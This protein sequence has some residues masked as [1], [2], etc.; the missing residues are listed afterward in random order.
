MS[1]GIVEKINEFYKK[2][3][4]EFILMGHSQGGA[5]TF[6][7][8]SYLY[9]DIHN[10]IPDDI[11]FK[12]YNSAAPKPGNLY[13]SYD[14]SYINRGGWA[15]RVVNTLDWVPETPI[16]VQT[17]EDFNEINP[18]TNFDTFT[19]TMGWVQRAI[20][21]SVFNKTDRSLR[22]AQKRLLKYLGFKVYGFLEDYMPDMVEPEYVQSMNYAPAGDAIILPPT[23]RYYSEFVANT[24]QNVFLHHYGP[25]YYFLLKEHYLR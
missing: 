20:M 17:M 6:M 5:I 12:T 16:S 3:E 4:K 14:Y 11:V 18:F 22:K 23:E 2:G 25:A 15:F 9:Y 7:L 10:E 21:K 24:K 19:S 8:N 13:Y 1:S